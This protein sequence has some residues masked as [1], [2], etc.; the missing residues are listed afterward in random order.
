MLQ[1]TFNPG[2]K[3]L[4]GFRTTRPRTLQTKLPHTANK[5]PARC[6]QKNYTLQT[7]AKVLPMQDDIKRLGPCL[8]VLVVHGRVFTERDSHGCHENSDRKNS[9]P[10]N[11][12]LKKGLVNPKEAIYLS[13]PVYRCRIDRTVKN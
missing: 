5:T 11:L 3:L 2:L 8:V 6:K 1:L 13:S 9:D 10:S 12:F 7:K 4:T